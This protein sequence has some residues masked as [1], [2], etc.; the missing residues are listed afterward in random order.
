MLIYFEGIDKMGKTTQAQLLWDRLTKAH[1]NAIYLKQPG[2]EG[3]PLGNTLRDLINS[4]DNN[5]CPVANWLLHTASHAEQW[6][7]QIR[8]A[9]AED[10]IVIMDRSY[11]SA[12][13]YQSNQGIPEK[14]I[15]TLEM[16]VAGYAKPDLLFVFYSHNI[17]A[18][19]QKPDGTPMEMMPQDFRAGVNWKYFQLCEEF[20]GSLIRVDEY[21]NKPQK[22]SDEIWD[23]VME[24]L[25]EKTCE[26]A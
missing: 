11:L 1:Y 7:K 23:D 5:L 18:L 16:F 15:K 19:Q 13:A 14:L 17:N 20:K 6:D 9:L 8:P 4:K 12:I 10:K 3:T 24:E 21:F 25:K 2:N 26:S 22:L